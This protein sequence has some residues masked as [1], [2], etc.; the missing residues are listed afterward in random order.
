LGL[1]PCRMEQASDAPKACD[2]GVAQ[3]NG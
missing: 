1:V 2:V 3:E